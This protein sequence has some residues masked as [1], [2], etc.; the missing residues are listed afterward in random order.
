MCTLT[1][2]IPKMKLEIEFFNIFTTF[3]LF[4][5][6]VA[7]TS[8]HLSMNFRIQQTAEHMD[9]P[10]L[11]KLANVI[12]FGWPRKPKYLQI[13]CFGCMNKLTIGPVRVFWSLWL[14]LLPFFVTT[15]KSLSHNMQSRSMLFTFP[16]RISIIHALG[17]G[18]LVSSSPPR[19]EGPHTGEPL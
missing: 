17:A 16:G 4:Q 18:P 5:M 10:N 8:V 6:W 9:S 7:K 14:L 13:I 11:R 3:L 19:S 15:S 12:L 1:T 2:Y